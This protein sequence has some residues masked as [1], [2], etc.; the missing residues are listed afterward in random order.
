MD[1]M[2]LI[3]GFT[4]MIQVG[5]MSQEAADGLKMI[6]QRVMNGGSLTPQER[7]MFMGVMG[8]MPA[9]A[10]PQ[11]EVP[12]GQGVMMPQNYQVDGQNV[13]MTEDQYRNAVNSGQITQDQMSYGIDGKSMSATPMEMER[14]Q[15]S[16]RITPNNA[17]SRKQEADMAE[18]NVE[19]MEENA[20]LFMAKMG[21]SHDESGLEVSDD[22][23]INFLLLCQREYVMP[24]G[25]EY[26]Y[27]EDDEPMMEMPHGKDVKV[28]VMKLDGGNVHD[29]MNELLGG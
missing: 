27:E 7:E 24:S 6:A 9:G 23:L 16:G 26:E 4:S 2:E 15:R 10:A 22:Q 25:E 28:K 11:M 14:M 12:A 29:M 3:K 5:D 18:V 17:I 1:D 19:N 20:E 13:Q 8:A 21:F